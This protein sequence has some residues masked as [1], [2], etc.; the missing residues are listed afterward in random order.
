MPLVKA[1]NSSGLILPV[2]TRTTAIDGDF[3]FMIDATTNIPYRITKA[4]LLAGLSSSGTSGSSGGSGGG[5]DSY[6]SNVVLLLHGDETDGS[7]VITNSGKNTY[8]VSISNP[9][10]GVKNSSTRAKFNN[11]L[12]FDG[13]SSLNCVSSSFNVG[14]Q[15]CTIEFFVN[16]NSTVLLFDMRPDGGNGAFPAL[17]LNGGNLTLYFNTVDAISTLAALTMNTWY[18]IAVKKIGTTTQLWLN[19]TKLGEFASGDWASS[20]RIKIGENSSPAPGTN[21]NGYID[22]FRF[23]LGTARDVS[24]VP[25]A[26][27]PTSA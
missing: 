20:G 16:I 22:E 26:A 4:D 17:Y 1:V 9:N 14:S 8:S 13:S 3:V 11:S 7:S 24:V 5:T 23:T 21:L 19:G 18:Y 25:S 2:E 10:N 15:D 6:S 12:Y 27:F